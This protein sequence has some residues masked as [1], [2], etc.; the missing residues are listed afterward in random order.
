[1]LL[2]H[3]RAR[4]EWAYNWSDVLRDAFPKQGSDAQ[5]INLML[6]AGIRF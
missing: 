3:R 1:M 4:A 2:V 6:T 5:E